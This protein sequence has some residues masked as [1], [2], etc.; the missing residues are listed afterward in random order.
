MTLDAKK[1]N[2]ACAVLSEC[3]PKLVRLLTN[4]F[5]LAVLLASVAGDV[6]AQAQRE[7]SEIEATKEIDWNFWGKP[8]ENQTGTFK[9]NLRA[10]AKDM[11]I[12]TTKSENGDSSW[13]L[14]TGLPKKA[15]TTGLV[16]DG[17]NNPNCPFAQADIDF[18]ATVPFPTD[19]AQRIWTI[20]GTIHT[21]VEGAS[22]VMGSGEHGAQ[23]AK[24]SSNGK[25]TIS[26]GIVSGIEVRVGNKLKKTF[27]KIK[28][29]NSVP[30][31]T[32]TKPRWH[33]PTFIVL[34]E[35]ETG[36]SVIE[37]LFD[38][39]I[40]TTMNGNCSWDTLDGIVLD[41]PSDGASSATIS[42]GFNSPWII[43]APDTFFVSL[44][45]GEF[46]AA[47]SL[48]GLPW[49][50][51]YDGPDIVGAELLAS[52]VPVLEADYV[53]PDS[54]IVDTNTYQQTLIFESSAETELS[55]G[56]AIPTLTEWGM[57]IFC[58]LLFGW[59]AWVI[60]RRRKAVKVRI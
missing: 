12:D 18:K 41:V 37:R 49:T 57:I 44:A 48:E 6:S 9:W 53:V 59:M 27:K 43:S 7:K 46:V 21:K 31:G 36:D 26:S 58:A 45:N 52:S 47:G 20:T 29:T 2:K 32:T 4:F 54:L 38:L 15:K 51:T 30:F 14:T 23:T 28:F 33:D 5:C 1:A 8:A 22:A 42:G 11:H 19:A 40:E 17:P 34:H 13:T 50:F 55:F 35:I 10:T 56:E 24:A 39:T 16:G 3:R 60:V 25:M